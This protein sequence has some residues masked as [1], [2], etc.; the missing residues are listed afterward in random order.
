MALTRLRT[1]PS[2]PAP[3][4]RQD[5]TRLHVPSPARSK[6]GVYCSLSFTP[7]GAGQQGSLGV[8][9]RRSLQEAPCAARVLL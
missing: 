5:V 7:S 2:H 3:E 9:R 8:R 4:T 6:C 1:C